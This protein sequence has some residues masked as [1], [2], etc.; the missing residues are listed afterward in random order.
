MNPFSIGAMSFSHVEEI[1]LLLG[2]CFKQRARQT[3][4]S[5]NSATYHVTLELKMLDFKIY[6]RFLD[7]YHGAPSRMRKNKVQGG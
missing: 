2:P 3:K 7:N 6:L 4:S 5:R 1:Q